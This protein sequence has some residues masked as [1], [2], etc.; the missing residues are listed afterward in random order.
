MCFLPILLQHCIGNCMK[1]LYCAF[2]KQGLI[3]I[4]FPINNT[5]ERKHGPFH[6]HCQVPYSN[7]FEKIEH[8]SSLSLFMIIKALHVFV[9]KWKVWRTCLEKQSHQTEAIMILSW[10]ISFHLYFL[11]IIETTLCIK[12]YILLLEINITIHFF[13]MQLNKIPKPDF[14]SCIITHYMKVS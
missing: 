14:N 12:F 10:Y 8:T 7:H 6:Y 13:F 5:S 2:W 3:G 1:S 9:E 11:Y 4:A